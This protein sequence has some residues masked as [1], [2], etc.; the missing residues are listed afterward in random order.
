MQI[1]DPQRRD[2]VDGITNAGSVLYFLVTGH[3]GIDPG[4]YASAWNQPTFK[5]D[6][7]YMTILFS[8]GWRFPVEACDQNCRRQV[9][10]RWLRQTRY[11]PLT[12]LCAAED[13]CFACCAT[14]YSVVTLR[15]N[16]LKADL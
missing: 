13:E 1:S 5:G 7:R 16:A 15:V 2:T 8:L 3:A 6:L 9:S 4:D 11:L 14:K 10:P 12:G